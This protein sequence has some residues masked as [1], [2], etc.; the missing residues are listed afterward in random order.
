[1]GEVSFNSKS[2]GFLSFAKSTGIFFVGSSMSKIITLLLIPL[3]TNVLPTQ[4][5]GYYDLSITYATLL[6]SFL[7]CDIWSSVMRMM[8]D[9]LKGESPWKVIA[10][11]WVIFSASTI[12]YILIAL[13]LSLFIDIPSL[14][15]ILVY[16]VTTNCQS[17]FSGIARGKGNNVDFAVSGVLC[18]LLNVC[19]NLFLILLLHWGYESLYISYAAGFTIQCVYLFW[20]LQM[21]KHIHKPD[22]NQVRELFIY[23]APLGINSVAYWF[24]TSL[25][26]VAVSAVLS[27]SANGI[28]AIGSKFGSTVALATTCFTLAWQD[29]AFTSEI[30]PASFYSR[31]I[32]Q[33]TGFLLSSTA[34]LLP[35]ISLVFP[36][37][38]G[39]SYSTAYSVVPS[40][41]W[42]AVASAVSTFIGNIFYVIKDTKTIGVSMVIS[43]IV[44]GILV[45]PLTEYFGCFGANLSVLI[46]FILNI[47]IR[48]AILGKKMGIS[49]KLRSL[50]LPSVLLSVCSAAY[51]SESFGLNALTLIFSIFGVFMLYRSRIS[52]LLSAISSKV[53]RR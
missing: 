3:Y 4:D 13:G 27:L 46:S 51:F 45:Y 23:S 33:Y 35:M 16:G 48:C 5:Y 17:M 20:R 21:W 18:T 53:S 41:L 26:R 37:L 50:L 42:V 9:D 24:L 36:I 44:N 29:V 10:S 30:K 12:L 8:R 7:Y 14:G 31:A 32:S 39:S 11:G 47:V 38:V 22:V 25:S 6:T 40:F 15:W 1:M 28:F 43:C 19:L 34:V 52:T 49:V 2:S